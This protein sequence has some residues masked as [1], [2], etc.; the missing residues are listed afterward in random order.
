[1][2]MNHIYTTCCQKEKERHQAQGRNNEFLYFRSIFMCD[3]N[4]DAIVLS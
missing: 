3:N 4:F 2:D 1:M